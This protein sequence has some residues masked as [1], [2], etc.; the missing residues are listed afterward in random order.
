MWWLLINNEDVLSFKYYKE[1]V[2][3]GI[4]ELKKTQR[5]K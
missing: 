4:K 2:Y 1:A 5:K 3:H